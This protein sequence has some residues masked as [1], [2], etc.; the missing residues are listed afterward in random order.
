MNAALSSLMALRR[1]AVS[2]RQRGLHRVHTLP[3]RASAQ[4]VF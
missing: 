3:E 1:H 4:Q 2:T